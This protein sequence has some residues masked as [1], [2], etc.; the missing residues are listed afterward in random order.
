M[1]MAFTEGN[2]PSQAARITDRTRNMFRTILAENGVADTDEAI[3]EEEVAM[4]F[5]LSNK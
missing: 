3:L 2:T 5:K 1:K 4:L